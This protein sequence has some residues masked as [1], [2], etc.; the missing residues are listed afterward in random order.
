MAPAQKKIDPPAQIPYVGL[1]GM[2]FYPTTSISFEASRSSSIDALQEAMDGSRYVILL[3]QKDPEIENPRSTDLYRIGSLAII[4]QMAEVSFGTIKVL[5][6]GVARVKVKK[7]SR[8][9]GIGLATYEVIPNQQPEDVDSLVLEAL[10][11]KVKSSYEEFMYSSGFFQHSNFIF[12]EVL[13]MVQEEENPYRLA[14]MVCM[15]LDLKLPAQQAQLEEFRVVPRLESLISLMEHEIQ[16]VNITRGISEKVQDTIDQNQKEYILREQMKSIQEELGDALANDTHRLEEALEKSLM[17]EEFKEKV[18]VEIKKLSRMPANYPETAVQLNWLELLMEL[19]FGKVDAE[20]LDLDRA[21]KILNRDHYG[22]DKVKQRILEYI[23][24]R[25]LQVKTGDTSIKGP[26]LCMVGPPGVGKTS[27]AK[28]I[29]EALGR[30]YIRMSLGGIRDEAE[31]RGH[32]RTYIGAMPGRIVQGIRRAGTDNPLFLLDEVDKLGADFRGDPSSALLE[33]LDPEQNNSFRDHYVEFP[34]DLSKVLFLTTAN[35]SWDIPDPLLDRM[36]VIEL[37]GYTEEEKIQIAKRHLLPKQ[38]AQHA[39][40]PG[41]L[42]VSPTA[43]A[44]IISWY[45]SE[46]GVRQLDRELARLCRQAAMQIADGK[47]DK[48]EVKVGNLEDIL[49]KRKYD[50]EKALRK[51]EVGQATGLA[52]TYAGGDTLTIEVNVMPGQ[53]KIELTG[54]LGEVMKES[55]HAALTYIRSIAEELKLDPNFS[56]RLDI[57]IHVPAGAVPKDGPS[58]GITMA[59]ALASAL[60]GY[61]IRHD[62]AMTGEITLRGRVMPIGG[63]KEKAVAARRAGIKEILIPKENERDVEDIPES[64]RKAIKIRP[65]SNAGEVLKIALVK[66]GKDPNFPSLASLPADEDNPADLPED[67][68]QDNPEDAQDI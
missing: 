33:V 55:A 10:M 57:H 37:S 58:A 49:G 21:R 64:V 9:K 4:R 67:R 12:Q 52:W 11:R 30:H 1:R 24:V 22:L 44:R 6:E 34:Y 60:T 50:Y 46:A 14:D 29:A 62:L 23:A 51:D 16:I 41:Q 43:L 47:L 18:A 66:S 31:I 26:I 8:R 45:T 15:N 63:L 56:S 53:G 38:M 35:S 39:L 3:A 27:I 28:S 5:C 42:K 65:V 59:T 2:V 36:E 19:P 13:R 40:T 61:P 17:P 20:I 48:L 7:F 68:P 32:R 54:S 25:A